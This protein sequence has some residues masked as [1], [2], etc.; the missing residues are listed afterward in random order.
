MFTEKLTGTVTGLLEQIGK[1]LPEGTYL[2]GGTALAMH[3]NH[4][5]SFDLD[6]YTPNE[7]DVEMLRQQLEKA[8]PEFSV[9]STS[10]QTLIGKYKDTEISIFFYKYPLIKPLTKFKSLNIASIEDIAVM[11][12]EAIS[13]RGL[14]RDFYDL[15]KICQNQNWTLNDVLEM[16]AEKYPEAEASRPHI[17]KSLTYFDDAESQ[18]ERA[19]IID[20]DWQIVKEFFLK[21][22]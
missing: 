16:R 6:L 19:Q 22:K 15:Y 9:I 3:L 5:S 12:L 21:S 11:K 18:S 20:Q 8:Y 1:F 17:I 14:K 4:R 13:G 7:F 10:W 2:A